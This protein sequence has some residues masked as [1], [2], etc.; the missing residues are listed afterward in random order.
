MG[1]VV[2]T[3]QERK[4]LEKKLRLERYPHFSDR[5]KRIRYYERFADFKGAILEV[6]CE[7]QTVSF[8]S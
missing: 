2:T 8:E 3:S 7:H 1:R 5:I 6:F 4:L